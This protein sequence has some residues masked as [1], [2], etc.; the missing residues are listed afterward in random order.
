[1]KGLYQL[2]KMVVDKKNPISEEIRTF[3]TAALY[4][5]LCKYKNYAPLVCDLFL[6][7]DIYM[8]NK[9]VKEILDDYEIDIEF[10]DE[11]TEDNITF[12]VSNPGHIFVYDKETD[13]IKYEKADPFIIC[14]L[15]DATVSSLLNS[16]CHELGH[17]IKGE[18]NG[19]SLH[20]IG[21][22][23]EYYIRT[24]LSHCVYLYKYDEDTLTE[25]QQ[26]PYVDEAVN[27]IQTTEIMQ[28]ILKL[29]EFVDDP[30]M[31]EFLDTLDSKE[32][33]ID[34]GYDEIVKDF[35]GLWSI[36]E[37]KKAIEEGLIDGDIDHT[38]NKFNKLL[39]DQYGFWKMNDII[40]NLASIYFGEEINES[41]KSI[42]KEKLNKM[43][44]KIK[45][46]KK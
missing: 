31:L 25:E 29:K 26:F 5:M 42:E 34:H 10:E 40:D 30:E 36:E 22:D 24:G 1:M 27:C 44:Q 46:R 19:Y 16:F 4:G 11:D 13:S 17:I 35:R 39:G 9:P 14:S 18:I 38:I 2:A 32:L 12:A 41:S 8:D 33:A 20:N 23:Y 43:I 7:T 3:F 6:K 45:K 15:K 28:D 37:V 21:K